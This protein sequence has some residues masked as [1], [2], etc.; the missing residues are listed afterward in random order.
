MDVVKNFAH[1][2]GIVG[3]SFSGVEL[4]VELAL[5]DDQFAP[6]LI[7]AAAFTYAQSGLFSAEAPFPWSLDVD[8]ENDA[9]LFDGAYVKRQSTP[10]PDAIGYLFI[11]YEIEMLAKSSKL[12]QSA[13][14]NVVALDG[15]AEK[16]EVIESEP[17]WTHRTPFNPTL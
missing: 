16:L 6:L 8:E 11:D 10:T 3:F 5:D 9:A 1:Q 17:N 12:E 15:L 13:N 14:T 7:A 4:P 2:R